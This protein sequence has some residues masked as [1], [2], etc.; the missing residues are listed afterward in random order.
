MTTYI[1]PTNFNPNEFKA[2]LVAL[3]DGQTEPG[4]SRS[5]WA[6]DDKAAY[7]FKSLIP[8]QT[9]NINGQI[10]TVHIPNSIVSFNP[11]I[12]YRQFVLA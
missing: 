3:F 11:V 7:A 8:G 9:I 2:A 6:E 12:E 10:Y 4:N 5:D 1:A